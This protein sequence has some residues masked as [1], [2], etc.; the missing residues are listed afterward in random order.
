MFCD[1][2][3]WLFHCH[4]E[5]HVIS[6]LIATF[7]EAPLELQAQLKDKLPQ[8]HLDACAKLDVPVAGNAAGNTVDLFDLNGEPVPPKPLPKGFTA[9]G[10]VAL[11][12]SIITG[13]LGVGTIVWYGLAGDEGKPSARAAAA[14]EREK[15]EVAGRAGQ[16]VLETP[17]VGGP[18]R[19]D[20]I[21]VVSGGGMGE[22]L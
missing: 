21:T 18:G 2:G 3:V 5:W 12:F 14:A 19:G 15:T 16:G 20:E 1:L 9:R 6:G 7:V 22:R 10:I 11:V 13:L 17:A 8:D 4:I